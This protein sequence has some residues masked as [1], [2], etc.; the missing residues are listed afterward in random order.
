M[1]FEVLLDVAPAQDDMGTSQG[2]VGVQALPRSFTVSVVKVEGKAFKVRW[3]VQE[4]RH[5]VV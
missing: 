4:N 3:E 5:T 1:L 2:E